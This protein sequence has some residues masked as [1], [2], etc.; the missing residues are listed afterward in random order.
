MRRQPVAATSRRVFVFDYVT[1]IDPALST[2]GWKIV[3][4][5]HLAMVLP[6]LGAFFP[7]ESPIAWNWVLVVVALVGVIGAINLVSFDRMVDSRGYRSPPIMLVIAELSLATAAAGVL[8]YAIGGTTAI[9]RPLVFVPTLLAAMIGN[10]WVIALLWAVA[11]T[12]VTVSA[13]ATGVV[14]SEIP[15]IVLSYGVVWG[16]TA[17][18]VHLLAL[19]ALHSDD[20]VGGLA[21]IAGVAARVD[22]LDDGITQV[23]PLIATLA[24][25]T[26]VAAFRVTLD[27]DAPVGPYRFEPFAGPAGDQTGALEPP[28]VAEIDEARARNGVAL[29]PRHAVL[30]GEGTEGDIVAVVLEGMPQRPFDRLMT[31][32]NLERVAA[33]IDVLVNRSRYVA[34]LADLGRTDGL[35]GL[36]N[37]RSLFERLRHALEVARR[38]GEPL[39]IVMTDLDHFKA[40]NDSFGHLAGD[41]LLR[42]FAVR[43]RDRTRSVDLVARYGGEE[44]VLVLPDTDGDGARVLVDEL[45]ER[46]GVDPALAGVTFSAG[47]AVW[48]GSESLEEL[49]DRADTALYRAK[50]DGRDR[51]VL[52]PGAAP[53]LGDRPDR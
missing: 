26:R 34:R 10:R 3:G 47:I 2:F 49:I 19:A 43:I 4:L 20:Q 40:Y 9:Y 7:R 1:A 27:R 37:R 5:A 45:R 42:N 21:Q 8:S 23:T 35:T 13:V 30:L 53:R 18:M 6:I 33:Q 15:A 48:D 22:N 52:D 16:I 36:A 11:T 39:T 46:F 24:E 50:A 44:F 32:F 31:R 14:T 25:A 17:V 38:R 29:R 12:S 28:T 41:D 51:W